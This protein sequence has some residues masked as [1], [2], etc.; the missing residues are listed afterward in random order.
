STRLRYRGVIRLRS[1]RVR[2]VLAERPGIHELEVEVEGRIDRAL[3]YPAL[4][5]AAREGSTVLLNTT[6]VA[7][8]LGTGG[9]HVVVAVEGVMELDPSPAGHVVKARY[10]PSQ[11]KVLTVEEQDSPFR[12]RFEAVANLG[13]L[14][15]VWV[16]LHSMV[17]AACA[18]AKAAG[19]TRVAYVMTDGA[20]LPSAFS[21][22]LDGLRTR[23]LLDATITC[24]QAFGGDL[25]AV[26]V[27]SGLL[28]ARSIAEADVAVVADG[29][30]KVGTATRWGASDVAS[31]MSLNAAGILDGRPIA[32]LRLNFA[33]PSYRHYG[34][35]PH[36]LTVLQDVALVSVHVPVPRLPE[37]QR[38]MVWETLKDARLEERHQLVESGGEPALELLEE[39]GLVPESMGRRLRE[40]PALFLAAGAAG[41]L[42]G[43]MASGSAR[44]RREEEE[45]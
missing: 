26:N 39:R 32:A 11:V 2:R 19:A 44:W 13:G 28:A 40:E 45:R 43:R 3:A 12:D 29:P 22:Q 31:G 36:S 33:D 35:S 1:G 4:T 24:G 16:P 34:V 7:E 14:P 42:A 15:V 6:A 37:E 17:G 5:G 27:F 18:G 20:A 10:T 38:R 23:G 25:E 8:Q 21:R 41:V 30:G 9:Y